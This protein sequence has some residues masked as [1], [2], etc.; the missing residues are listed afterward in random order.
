[1]EDIER[2]KVTKLYNEFQNII[3]KM[4]ETEEKWM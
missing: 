4:R 3:G 2:E 1:M